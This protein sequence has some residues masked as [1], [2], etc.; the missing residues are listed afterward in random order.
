MGEQAEI[1]PLRE[2]TAIRGEVVY[3]QK[4]GNGH[5]YIRI[6]NPAEPHPLVRVAEV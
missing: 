5:F 1:A 3:C 2:E 4:L 6:E